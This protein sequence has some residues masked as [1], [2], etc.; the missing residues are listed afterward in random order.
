VR[1]ARPCW[2]RRPTPPAAC[3]TT[4][5]SAMASE[6][7]LSTGTPARLESSCQESAHPTERRPEHVPARS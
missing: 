3:R 2:G 5:R 1:S 4:G 6:A 7:Q